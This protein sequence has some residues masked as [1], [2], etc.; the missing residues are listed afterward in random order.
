M[1]GE[2][3]QVLT[4]SV[5]PDYFRTMGV[6]L[7]SGRPFSRSDLDGR[8]SESPKV[9][10]INEA[11]ARQYFG[12]IAAVG[13]RF[14]WG[15]APAAKYDTEV[16]GVVGNA[17]YGDLR[18]GARPLIY[19]P[20]AG[21]HYLILRAALPV[22]PITGLVRREIH[23]V[24]P[25]LQIEV[26]TVPQILDEAL[27]VERLLARLSS[28]FGLAALLLA[29]IG[30]YGLM[31]YAVSRRTKEIGIRVALGAQR[32]K[33]VQQVFGETLGLVAVGILFGAAAAS[34]MA[35][36]PG[37]LLFGVT[38]DDPLTLGVAMALLIAVA[39]LAGALPARRAARVEP[40]VA[41]RHE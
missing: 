36:L 38:A 11:M 16:V 33:V 9:A 32:S 13:R 37:S 10:I 22:S 35:R 12:S 28:F 6:P 29:S 8:A 4:T 14:G 1:P 39:A 2:E 31:A 19:Y 40:G 25:N 21:G 24:D 23:A 7:L 15:D 18:R 17:L 34:M 3:R 26:R 41:L 30:L 5:T 20:S 27:V